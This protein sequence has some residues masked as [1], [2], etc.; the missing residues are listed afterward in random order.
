MERLLAPSASAFSL[1]PCETRSGMQMRLAA[2]CIC[3]H[4][5]FDRPNVLEFGNC[6]VSQHHHLFVSSFSPLVSRFLGSGSA[7]ASARINDDK[8]EQSS[9]RTPPPRRNE[10]ALRST[11]D[12][13]AD[14]TA[15][16][17][18]AVICMNGSPSVRPLEQ[19]Q[20][21]LSA[22]LLVLT[23]PKL[24]CA[25]TDKQDHVFGR[26]VNGNTKPTRS[27]SSGTLN[28]RVSTATVWMASGFSRT[29]SP[30]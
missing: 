5:F 27:P 13:P 10:N 18:P 12:P 24:S 1:A 3:V 21:W 4:P 16:N 14:I 7:F 11:F 2:P 17:N 8:D 20:L 28:R 19:L 29:K 23:R 30:V 6:T 9:R 22:G 15:I 25:L 26:L